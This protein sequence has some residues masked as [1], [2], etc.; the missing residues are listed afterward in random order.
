MIE[1]KLQQFV[2]YKLFTILSFHALC[3]CHLPLNAW[4]VSE[5]S[6]V[7]ARSKNVDIKYSIDGV[8]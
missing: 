2:S 5:N 1:Y 6:E 3:L 4:R 8:C 7:D